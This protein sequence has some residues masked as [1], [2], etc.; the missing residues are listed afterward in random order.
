MSNILTIE[1]VTKKFGSFEAVTNLSLDLQAGQFITLLGP[2]GCGKSTTLRMVGGFDLPTAGR[3]VI[4]GVDATHVPPNKRNV[5]MVFQDYA[6]FPHLTVAKNVGFGLQMKGWGRDQIAQRVIELLKLVQLEAFAER[7]PHELSGGQRQRV[8]LARALA[9]DPAILL[10]D[11]P[12]G[13]LDARLRQDMQ[14]ELR[15]LQRATGKTFILVTHD[16]EE[17]L[18]M[19]DVV[20][21]M[22]RGRIEQA[23]TPEEL[24]NNPQTEFVARFIGEM[25]FLGERDGEMHN[26]VMSFAWG[27]HQVFAS[28]SN[29][30]WPTNA[31][32][33]VRPEDIRLSSEQ[34]AGPNAFPARVKDRIFRGS[35]VH[36]LIDVSGNRLAAVGRQYELPLD[37]DNVWVSWAV[38]RTHVLA[39][40]KH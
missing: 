8:A 33:A 31:L 30:K 38:D 2:S 13:A 14:M 29:D 10:L 39:A 18:T 12:L 23:G 40:A 20:V 35:N 4:G 37:A 21:V 6:L 1:N 3:I 26:D 19:S 36:Y 16:Q 7:L 28:K 22:N 32:A 15:N 34:P 17:A 25:N 5:N 27:D 24:Y 11:E 9:P